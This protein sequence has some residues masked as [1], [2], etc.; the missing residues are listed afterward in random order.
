MR[1][2]KFRAWD[3]KNKLYIFFDKTDILDGYG[4]ELIDFSIPW[5]DWDQFTGLHDKN[6]KEIYEGDILT[7]FDRKDQ[8]WEVKWENIFSFSSW[9][10]V[11]KCIVIGNIHENPELIK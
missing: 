3:E 10:P 5:S 9:H 2:I 1:E 6:G 11:D 8:I 4:F 7:W